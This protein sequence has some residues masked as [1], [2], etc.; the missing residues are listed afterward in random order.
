[1]NMDRGDQPLALH[2]RARWRGMREV[3]G[4][5]PLAMK[6]L[7]AERARRSGD[8]WRGVSAQELKQNHGFPQFFPS[9]PLT[10][11]ASASSF[12]SDPE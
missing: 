10:K 12:S 9:F 3:L 2:T 7:P 11:S 8:V 1:M 6:R 5:P 4:M